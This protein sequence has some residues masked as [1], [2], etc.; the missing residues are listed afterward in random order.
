M[1]RVAERRYLFARSEM[2]VEDV[3]GKPRILG[4]AAVFDDPVE[5]WPGFKE[6][7][8]RGAFKKTIDESDV[9]GLFNH[10]PDYVLGRNKAKTLRLSEDDRGLAYTIEPPATDLIREL[11]VEPIRRGDITG[12][13]FSFDTIRSERTITDEVELRELLEVRLW[14]VGPVT[15]PAYPSTD[16]EIRKALEACNSLDELA[17]LSCLRAG[18]LTDEEI[19]TMVRRMDEI[20]QGEEPE[21]RSTPTP[22]LDLASRRIRAASLEV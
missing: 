20:L 17:F 1:S 9:R 7:V 5:L 3:D 19:R 10:N 16:T 13:S 2:R 12:S 22:L 21:P 14:D 18:G 15:F 8:R 6:V 4:H 11:V